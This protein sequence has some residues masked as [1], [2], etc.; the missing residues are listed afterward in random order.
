MVNNWEKGRTSSAEK[1]SLRQHIYS[2]PL[3]FALDDTGLLK[4]SK[5]IFD[6]AGGSGTN[7]GPMNLRRSLR[8]PVLKKRQPGPCAAIIVLSMR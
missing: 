6:V 4:D 1:W 7:S 3:G 5:R 8:K 2:M